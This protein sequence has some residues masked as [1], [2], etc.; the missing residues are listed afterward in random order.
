MSQLGE[1]S[2]KRL[3][4]L[5]ASLMAMS[6]LAIDLY[7]PAMPV[8]AQDFSTTMPMMQ[9]TL[10]IY[11]AGY[12][13]GL[14]LFGPLS[15]INPRRK[16]AIIGVA[17][18]T[19]CSFAQIFCQSIEAFFAL[20]FAQA[21]IVSSALVI[22]PAT[23]REYYGKNTAKGLSYVSMV[24]MLAPMIAPTIGSVLLSISGWPLI[25]IALTSYAVVMLVL[26]I[27]FLPE[28]KQRSPK[29]KSL[30]FFSRYKLVFTRKKARTDLLTSMVVSLAFFSYITAIP[31]VY[32]SVYQL[33]EFQFSVLFGVAVFA[34]MTAHFINSRL[35]T[36]VGSR[37]MLNG[38]LLVAMTF[39]IA[40]VIST[41]THA[42][43]AIF[44]ASL[45][46]LMGSLSVIAVNADALV[47]SR[48]KMHLGT[49]T[50][51]IGV[52]RFGVGALAGPILAFFH[53]G[54]ATVFASLMFSCIAFIAILQLPTNI[55]LRKY[56]QQL[57]QLS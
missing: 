21:F 9:N 1:H 16:L 19:L 11:L 17:G 35:V 48:F 45:L 23:I 7:L 12:A 32:L 18:F 49:A 26:V 14:I 47:F 37:A 22:I 44:V 54:T 15:D 24:M 40:L 8:M 30:E 25:F 55:R 42:H 36:K 31:F 2:L 13:C 4:I 51:V 39:S 10:S 29:P 20:R 27:R 41:V 52:L 34:L 56:R 50:A 43:I 6:P 38:G 3:I 57:K 5:L 28:K 53:D 46:P 33:S